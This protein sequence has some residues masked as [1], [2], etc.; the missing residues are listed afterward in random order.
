[1]KS[2][3][4]GNKEL[5]VGSNGIQPTCHCIDVAVFNSMEDLMFE[6]W[7]ARGHQGVRVIEKL[8]IHCRPNVPSHENNYFHKEGN[9]KESS[10]SSV[11]LD[12][13]PS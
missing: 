13:R 9:T 4:L 1:M 5:G 7:L 2:Q 12:V 10:H 3:K 8:I 6:F 11:N